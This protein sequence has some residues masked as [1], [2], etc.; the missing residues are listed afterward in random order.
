MQ[1]QRLQTGV[2]VCDRNATMASRKWKNS[3]G[4]IRQYK[5]EREKT[6]AWVQKAPVCNL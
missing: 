5:N 2:R 6:F 4:S 3:N 1:A